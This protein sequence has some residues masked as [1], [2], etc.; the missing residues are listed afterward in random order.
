MF[1]LSQSCTLEL[2][3][4]SKLLILNIID[5]TYSALAGMFM[6]YISYRFP[7]TYIIRY[8]LHTLSML[9]AMKIKKQNGIIRVINNDVSVVYPI[10]LIILA[11]LSLLKSLGI[12]AFYVKLACIYYLSLTAIKR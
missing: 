5:K 4:K 6:H 10:F 2:P 1:V 11:S 7:T 8:K 3:N 9:M 12:S